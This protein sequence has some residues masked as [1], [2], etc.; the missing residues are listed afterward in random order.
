MRIRES[1]TL[2]VRA[3]RGLLIGFGIAAGLIAIGLIRALLR[4]GPLLIRPEDERVLA[5]YATGCLLGSVV[6]SII[7][8]HLRTK[9]A[10]N[11][12]F[13]L[14]G[15]IFMAAIFAE[16]AGLAMGLGWWAGAAVFGSVTGIV[17]G[18]AW[19]LGKGLNDPL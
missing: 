1:Q 17:I 19:I 3:L 9:A 11:A 6:V 16:T 5:Y 13:A 18:N 15:T 7:W 8:P 10:R 12:G 2:G 4:G 14:G